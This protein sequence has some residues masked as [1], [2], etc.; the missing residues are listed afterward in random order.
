MSG[1][2]HLVFWTGRPFTSSFEPLRFVARRCSS[3]LRGF[4]QTDHLSMTGMGRVFG[5]FVLRSPFGRLARSRWAALLRSSFCALTRSNDSFTRN[6]F[7][8]HT[9]SFVWTKNAV[10]SWFWLSRSSRIVRRFEAHSRMGLLILRCSVSL[11]RSLL[12]VR[13]ASKPVLTF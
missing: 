11:A 13:L 10:T 4:S 7:G 2:I 3:F 8:S 5:R 9:R 12:S 6:P 1:G